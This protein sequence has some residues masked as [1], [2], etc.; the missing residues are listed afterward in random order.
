M[1]C[2]YRATYAAAH[3]CMVFVLIAGGIS[4]APAR[5]QTQAL[6]EEEEAPSLDAQQADTLRRLLASAPQPSRPG[7]LA[8]IYR[9]RV[10]A[11][12]R[13]RDA[14]RELAEIQTGLQKVGISDKAAYGLFELLAQYQIDRGDLVSSLKAR[15]QALAVTSSSRQELHQ[16]A[17]VASLQS[18][19]RDRVGAAATLARAQEVLRQ[20]RSD[21]S[22]SR[23]GDLW[24]AQHSLSVGIYQSMY[25]SGSEAETAFQSCIASIRA[26]RAKLSDPAD[27]S[28]VYLVRCTSALTSLFLRDGRLEEAA[29]LAV[30]V[31]ELARDYGEMQQRAVFASQ[32]SPTLAR[33]EIERGRL[34][35]ANFIIEDSIDSMRKAG[36][37]EGSK[38]LANFRGLQAD[39]EVLRGNWQ[40]AD[41][42]YTARRRGLMTNAAQARQVGTARLEWGYALL[43]LGYHERAFDMIQSIAD[44]RKERFGETT[45]MWWQARGFLALALVANGQRERALNEFAAA[46]PRIIELGHGER[47]SAESGLLRST[48]LNWIFEGY[49]ALLADMANR[50]ERT[51]NLDPT[52]PTDQAFRLAD[53]VRG[54]TVQR[55]LADAASRAVTA[56]QGLADLLRRYQDGQRELGSLSDGLGSLVSRGRVASMDDVVA[57]IRADL[58]SMRRDQMQLQREIER[59]YPDYAALL[60]PKPPGISDVRKLLRPG[61]V[62]VSVL[63]GETRTYVW[64]VSQSG[65]LAFVQT[66]LKAVE[67]A[68]QVQKLRRTLNPAEVANAAAIPAFDFTTSHALYEQLLG[69]MKAVIQ[70]AQ[71]MIVIP[72]AELSELPFAVLTTMPLD[73]AGRLPRTSDYINA[74]WLI[75]KVAIVQLPSTTALVALRREA[76][77]PTYEREF[78]G[79]GDPLFAADAKPVAAASRGF[80]PRGG[81]LAST[82]AAHDGNKTHESQLDRLQ[83]LPE[84]AEELREIGTLLG[85]DENRDLFLGDRATETNVKAS[86]LG[87]YRIVMFATHGLVPGDLPGLSQPAL[88]LSNPTLTGG[89]EDGLVLM[90]EIL[91]LK[92]QAEWVVLSACNTAS[93]AGAGEAISGLGRA[94]FFAGARALLVTQWPIETN[95]ARLLTTA[96]FRSQSRQPQRPRAMA[97]QQASLDLMRQQSDTAGGLDYSHPMFWAPFVL[98]GDGN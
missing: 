50:G 57:R 63:V 66:P 79:F 75:K 48:R 54:S 24:Q 43:R 17:L 32:L 34:D 89:N 72:H 27:T 83:A 82:A 47:S 37:G 25:G 19:L 80:S 61:E 31:R 5:A 93:P 29:V 39:I 44:S 49:I 92:L 30:E 58:E 4:F 2:F 33:V 10:L 41:E 94:F 78:V 98:V 36:A 64:A 18:R 40:K 1:F 85:A 87:R 81:P 42:I 97:L 91:S 52:D 62:L 7:E 9:E 51:S 46:V 20:L 56:E 21:R 28:S 45:Y 76:R 59:R 53:L 95:S 71:S 90:E 3:V 69:P 35:S 6:E 60:E 84:T 73:L 38:H 14:N 55:A 74:P 8:I 23:V 96:I 16:L 15:Q 12:R 65:G 86:D 22:W 11:A 13:L 77:K 26:Y 70:D 88:A 68:R 67:V